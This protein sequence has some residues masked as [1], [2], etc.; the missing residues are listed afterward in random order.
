MR[1][2]LERG[3]LRQ[4]LEPVLGGDVGRLERARAQA[5]RARDVD[6]AAP[7]ALVHAG[8]RRADEQERRLDHEPLHQAEV[9][10]IELGDRAHPLD[11]GVVDE[12]VDIE[13]EV[14]ERRGVGEV[15]DPRLAA[16]LVGDAARR[17]RALGRR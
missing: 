5:V 7:A 8:Q 10:G 17:R 2:A 12:D 13:R 1:A 3:H 15:D 6:D 14:V 9:L 4:A 16:D 11:A